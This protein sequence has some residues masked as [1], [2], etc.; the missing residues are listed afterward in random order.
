MSNT[1]FR[2]LADALRAELAKPFAEEDVM[3]EQDAIERVATAVHDEA[4]HVWP[5]SDEDQN[6]Y[7]DR[8]WQ[9]IAAA[10]ITAYNAYLRER[11]KDADVVEAAARGV[12]AEVWKGDEYLMPWEKANQDRYRE[13]ARGAL[14]A[15]LDAMIGKENDDER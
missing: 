12:H 10:A 3:T 5:R 13:E 15:V 6:E 9:E 8:Y 2:P 11:S 7:R 14:T 4:I 1:D